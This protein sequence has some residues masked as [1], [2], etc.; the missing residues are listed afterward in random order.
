MYNKIHFKNTENIT[1]LYVANSTAR[2]VT[3]RFLAESGMVVTG[4]HVLPCQKAPCIISGFDSEKNDFAG[5][6][7]VFTVAEREA[8]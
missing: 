8:S 4:F 1:S 6:L 5:R 7:P 3:F 2:G